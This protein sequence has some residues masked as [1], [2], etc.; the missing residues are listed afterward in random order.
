MEVGSCFIYDQSSDFYINLPDLSCTDGSPLPLFDTT[1]GKTYQK[2]DGQLRLIRIETLEYSDVRNFI[3]YN[4]DLG[5]IP[6][7]DVNI[8][9]LTVS[10]FVICLFMIIYRW[11]FRL[12]A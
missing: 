5:K 3:G 11:F 1:T 9:L 4:Y 6:L 10:A 7:Y 8:V 12:R 2:R